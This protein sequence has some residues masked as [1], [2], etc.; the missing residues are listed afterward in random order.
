MIDVF[1]Y[2]SVKND[3]NLQ[4]KHASKREQFIQIFDDNIWKK[5]Q[6]W[7][8]LHKSILSYKF[9]HYDNFERREFSEKNDRK[10]NQK[11]IFY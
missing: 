9:F 2:I 4:K 10:Y 7:I 11:L 1:I 5:N 3:H 6:S 8:L